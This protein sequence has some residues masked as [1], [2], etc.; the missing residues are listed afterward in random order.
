MNPFAINSVSLPIFARIFSFIFQQVNTMIN[1]LLLIQ[2]GDSSI[3]DL[4]NHALQTECVLVVMLMLTLMLTLLILCGFFW[5]FWGFFG[6][7]YFRTVVIIYYT[8]HIIINYLLHY[9]IPIKTTL[10][11]RIYFMSWQWG[12]E[13]KC[14][15]RCK[16]YHYYYYSITIVVQN[17]QETIC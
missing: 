8:N 10:L 5:V 3:I 14:K 2:S 4:I 9:N 15:C 6:G 17:I 11:F 1:Q 16:Y 7:Q 13:R 12:T